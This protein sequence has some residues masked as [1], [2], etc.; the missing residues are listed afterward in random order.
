M[1]LMMRWVSAQVCPSKQVAAMPTAD[2]VSKALNSKIAMMIAAVYRML[3][4]IIWSSEIVIVNARQ[5]NT[6]MDLKAVVRRSRRK[7]TQVL[8]MVIIV[9]IFFKITIIIIFIILMQGRDMASQ[10]L[11]SALS[12]VNLGGA[13]HG[14][15]DSRWVWF[16]T[17]C[18]CTNNG[19]LHCIDWNLSWKHGNW[20]DIMITMAG[21]CFLLLKFLISIRHEIGWG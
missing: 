13:G 1:L 9:I 4:W 15:R 3:T 16:G 11:S 14:V 21:Q 20:S 18:Q 6:W 8:K 17:M 5:A 10:R 7:L 19:T 2:F 12:L